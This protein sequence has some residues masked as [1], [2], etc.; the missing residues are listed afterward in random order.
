MV[1]TKEMIEKQDMKEKRGWFD[2]TENLKLFLWVFFSSLVVLLV[3]DF[4]IGK[5]PDFAFEGVPN[6]FAA[7]GFISCVML[8]LVAKVLRMI[9][10]RE[11]DYYD[12]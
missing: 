4:F 1:G 5:H 3:V 6:I 10:M 7:Y 11:E 12:D 9:L 8:V 2:K